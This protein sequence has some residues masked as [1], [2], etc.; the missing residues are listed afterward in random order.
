M[1]DE[2]WLVESY[3][4]VA[5]CTIKIL[6]FF[7]LSTVLPFMFIHNEI[8]QCEWATA[9]VFGHATL[10]HVIISR[11][12]IPRRFL[13]WRLITWKTSS[14]LNPG[15]RRKNCEGNSS[16]TPEIPA[17]ITHGLRMTLQSGFLM[18][19]FFFPSTRSFHSSHYK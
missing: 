1:M 17:G 7:S 15:G 3:V 2:V 9:R 4:V 13:H 18:A 6:R 16:S 14:A 10:I 5:S 19:T 8:S 12:T 11:S